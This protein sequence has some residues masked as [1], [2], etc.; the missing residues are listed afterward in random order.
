[1]P[2]SRLRP[3]SLVLAALFPAALFGVLNVSVRRDVVAAA[4]PETVVMMLRPAVVIIDRSSH[5]TP[6][7]PLIRVPIDSIPM[8]IP[9]LAIERTETILG[10]GRMAAH[11]TIEVDARPYA[12]RA[13]LRPG[14]AATVVL[15]VQVMPSGELAAVVTELS[16][17]SSAI[18]A[19]A[20]EY[21]RALGWVAGR[22]DGIPEAQWIR[23]GVTLQG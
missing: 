8:E 17:G 10:A 18:D 5:P 19:T 13:G 20:A 21:V 6:D 2:S 7:A 4:E 9:D 22:I 16:S 11:P 14:E 12:V 15:R 23:W 3:G 1:M